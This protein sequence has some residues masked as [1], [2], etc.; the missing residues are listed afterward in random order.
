MKTQQ[1][2]TACSLKKRRF[3]GLKSLLAVFSKHTP[4]QM[5]R[6][7]IL[8]QT[9]MVNKRMDPFAAEN[10]EAY[11]LSAHYFT[12]AQM[13]HPVPIANMKP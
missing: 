6:I 4:S 12:K 2:L 13:M 8:I 11:L 3:R 7:T 9:Q 5:R 10:V 1:L